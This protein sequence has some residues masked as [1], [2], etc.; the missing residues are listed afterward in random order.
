M[1]NS[2][3]IMEN[4]A[5]TLYKINDTCRLRWSPRAYS[6][7]TIDEEIIRQIFEAAR[8]APSA[9]NEQPWRFILGLKGTETYEMIRNTLVEFNQI[10]TEPAPM[11]VM[12][13]AKKTFDLNG[14][15]NST[16][17]YDLGQA[18]SQMVH[19]AHEDGLYAHQMSGFD[20][21]KARVLFKIPENCI[22]VSV[23]AFGYMG[24]TDHLPENIA[25]QEC[26]PRERNDFESFVFHD[27][28]G[29]SSNLF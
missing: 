13:I 15:P 3:N 7:K 12:N 27:E 28:F 20:P 22:A 9:F 23:T 1:D 21:E 5:N 18:V 8:W 16:H 2:A 17:A 14:N 26:K 29:K 19:Q 25:E 10:W 11:L 24:D 4:P 6:D